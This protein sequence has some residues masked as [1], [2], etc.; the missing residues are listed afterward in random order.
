MGLLGDIGGNQPNNHG[1]VDL[2]SVSFVQI[3]D[4]ELNV[5]GWR[6]REDFEY[7]TTESIRLFDS[8]DEAIEAW[9]ESR[10]DD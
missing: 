5:I 6:Y 9:R 3:R 7:M 1:E 8:L 2:Y 10:D 4:G